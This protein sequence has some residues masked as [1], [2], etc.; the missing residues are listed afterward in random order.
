MS[1]QCQALHVSALLAL[2]Q[3]C[4]QLWWA[5]RGVQLLTVLLRH[6]LKGL[7]PEDMLIYQQIAAARNM[8]EGHDIAASIQ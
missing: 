1:L 3:E 6:R 8:G 7:Y 5:L 4:M 2:L